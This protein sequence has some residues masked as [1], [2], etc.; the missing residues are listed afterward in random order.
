MKFIILLAGLMGI[1]NV[2]A[3]VHTN[4]YL[5][6]NHGAAVTVQS[7]ALVT[8]QGD[9][10]NNQAGVTGITHLD[11]SGFIWLQGNAYGD[12]A[13]KQAGT[14]TLRVQNKTSLYAAPY[15]AENYQV[16]Q[17]GYRVNGGQTAVGGTDDGSFYDLELDNQNGLVFVKTNT[18]VRNSV[19]FSPAAVSAD[20]ATIAPNGTVNRIL[21]YDPGTA[22]APATAPANGA[23]YTAV[24][25]M[26]NTAA[27]L[28]NFKNVSTNLAANTTVLDNAYVQGKLR[29]AIEASSGGEYGFPLGLEPGTSST[30]A[31]GIQ[32]AAVTM[33]DNTYDVLTG[34]FQ[35]GSG[36]P[37][38]YNKDAGC[39]ITYCT[40]GDVHGEWNITASGS[41]TE[42]YAMTIYPQDYT[43]PCYSGGNYAVTKNDAYS[44]TGCGASPTGLTRTGMS[45][46]SDF[47]FAS[48]AYVLPVKLISF[49][50]FP[51]GNNVMLN[52]KV[53]EEINTSHY[54]VEYSANGSG[55][56][57]IGIVAATG[58][59]NYSFIHT[60]PGP[61]KNYYRLRMTDH[62]D[63]Y[64]FSPV[65][66][67]NMSDD[68]GLTVYP[69]PARDIINITAGRDWAQGAAAI[70][71]VAMDGKTVIQ[72]TVGRLTGTTALDLS[73]VSSGT[74]LIHIQTNQRQVVK[75][76]EVVR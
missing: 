35:Q 38:A 45:G 16:I 61:G 17:G 7:N 2:N 65:R 75:K 63:H 43:E 72:K 60:N 13:F 29:R 1:T 41:G 46:F 52:W 76:I 31:R 10:T 15:A 68:T 51:E 47:G 37:G 22:V 20:G 25:G 73:Q 59:H 27:G 32:Y 5:W 71:I 28:A 74:Y 3:Q 33:T 42:N 62:D 58:S 49:T 40:Y 64:D 36:N 67:V 69:N 66:W 9:M 48:T 44:G 21:T 6:Y 18:D 12:N 8:I 26:M 11:N 30:A 50:A 4:D 54:Q 23:S 14:G 56:S 19:N 55:Y 24:F 57:P 34:Y 39:G 53:A 70:R